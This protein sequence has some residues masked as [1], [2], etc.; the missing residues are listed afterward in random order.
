M[1]H[2]SLHIMK[3]FL[4]LLFTMGS[5]V[6]LSSCA[7]PYQIATSD[8]D[9]GFHSMQIDSITYSVWF[10]AV[11]NTPFVD[12]NRYEIYGAAQLTLQKGYDHFIIM[13]TLNSLPT[14]RMYRSTP[15]DNTFETAYDARAIVTT[16]APNIQK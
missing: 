3:T 4:A 1:K 16:M 7:T 13:G 2:K 9:P 11:A 8:S 5:I 12:V 10:T 6:T 15:E 14:I